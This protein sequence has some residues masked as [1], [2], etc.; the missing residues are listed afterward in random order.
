GI[1][2]GARAAEVAAARAA[3]NALAATRAMFRM[4]SPSKAFREIGVYAGEGLALGLL[5]SRNTVARAATQMAQAALPNRPLGVSSLP[6]LA[7]GTGVPA[8]RSAGVSHNRT[9]NNTWHV[10]TASQDP[11]AV[12]AALQA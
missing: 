6:T 9:V 10:H 5:D 4:A 11:R 3:S 1:A 2:A 8:A 12:A 7:G